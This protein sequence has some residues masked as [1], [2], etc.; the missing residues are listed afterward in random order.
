[1][2]WDYVFSLFME[3]FNDLYNYILLIVD[4][5]WYLII[6]FFCNCLREIVVD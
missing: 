6:L 2:N 4:E 5:N 3:I 1:M